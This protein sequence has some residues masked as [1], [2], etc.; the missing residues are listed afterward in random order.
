MHSKQPGLLDAAGPGHGA[1]YWDECPPVV[2]SKMPVHTGTSQQVQNWVHLDICSFWVGLSR[3]LY[4][5][6]SLTRTFLHQRHSP[7]PW[8]T[9]ASRLKRLPKP[10]QSQVHTRVTV[11]KPGL[12]NR[13]QARV[14]KFMLKLY[15]S[16]YSEWFI[17]IIEGSGIP[18]RDSRLNLWPA[19]SLLPRLLGLQGRLFWEFL[20]WSDKSTP[21]TNISTREGT[22]QLRKRPETLSGMERCPQ[23]NQHYNLHFRL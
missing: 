8:V 18:F 21:G 2:E 11:R 17:N 15:V 10:I 23:Q 16:F 12:C 5:K 19:P 14:S 6:I 9:P 22:R 13:Q 7:P 20:R 3:R 1:E 4:D